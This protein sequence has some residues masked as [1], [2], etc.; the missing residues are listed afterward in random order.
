M[1]KKRRKN[2]R[3]LFIRFRKDRKSEDN[4]IKFLESRGFK[5]IITS[6][7]NVAVDVLIK[8]LSVDVPQKEARSW[9][10]KL[11]KETWIEKVTIR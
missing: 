4:A 9:K 2:Q 10:E 5:N 7:R 3:R 1:E 11:E 8:M 6:Y